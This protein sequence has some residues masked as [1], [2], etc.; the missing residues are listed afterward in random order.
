MHSIY[1]Y[2]F[3]K[4][5]ITDSMKKFLLLVFI[6]IVIL[7]PKSGADAEGNFVIDSFESNVALQEDGI[8]QVSETI[9][10]TF[11]VS[12]HGI[13]RDIPIVY[14][15]A[16]NVKKFTEV[17][18]ES[19]T[20]GKNDIRY[21]IERNK[22]NLRIKIGDPNILVL[23]EKQYWIVYNVA[24]VIQSFDDHDELYW[25]VTG[26]DWQVPITKVSATASIPSDEI[27]KTTC[28]IGSYGSSEVCAHSIENNKAIFSSLRSLS[29]GEGLTFVIGFPKGI[30]PII[31][32][33][34]PLT[35]EHPKVMQTIVFGFFL[36]LIP[37]LCFLFYLWWRKGRDDYYQRK[38][39]NDPDQKETI[40]PLFG[41]Y[42]PIVP[43]YD[44]PINLRPAEIGVLIDEK[45]DSQD[46][47]ATLV[48]LGVRGY[49]TITEKAKAGLF[50]KSDYQLDRTDKQENDLLPYEQKL[51]KSLFSQS[52][53]I[54]LHDIKTNK[55]VKTGDFGKDFFTSSPAEDFFAQLPEIKTSIYQSVT[56]KKLFFSNPESVRS[57]YRIIAGV[58]V[59]I[60]V[61][62]LFV[63]SDFMSYTGHSMGYWL[64]LGLSGG[65]LVSAIF[66]GFLATYMPKRTAYGREIYRQALGYKLFVS[67]TEKYRQPFFEKEN[68]FM[69]V[70][71]Y[72]MVF[73][74]TDKLVKAMKEMHIDPNPGVWFIGTGTFNPDSL[75][76]SIN[77]FSS[78]LSSGIASSP[79]GSGFS[80]GGFSGGGFGGGGG[81]SW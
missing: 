16:D 46:V 53:S 48:D 42:E 44:S 28:Y 3:L 77:D 5:V 50:P 60:L 29:S 7:L 34:A 31:T 78:A 52:K 58:I 51:L 22:N 62:Y 11:S 54:S 4:G 1:F 49:L 2:D 14:Q 40:K 76:A 63:F 56:E 68:I 33:N 38:S 27:N 80:S 25:N 17:N 8:I 36:F 59:F 47:S 23:G 41:A 61:I 67:G 20:D 72:A 81:G 35:I 73:G 39:L 24:G 69:E 6:A 75:S 19:V 65:A 13:Y 18:I 74:V 37:A 43:E 45:A 64:A 21:N 26:N 57:K 32:I 12:S 9:N 30:V 79:N 10:V 70:L 55:Q 66:L 71:P 15:Q